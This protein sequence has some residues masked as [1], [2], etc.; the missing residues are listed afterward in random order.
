MQRHW[1]NR[2]RLLVRLK[3]HQRPPLQRVSL[4]LQSRSSGL[5][6]IFKTWPVPTTLHRDRPPTSRSH[7]FLQNNRL[8]ICMVALRLL[9]NHNRPA[10]RLKSDRLPTTPQILLAPTHLL[11]TRFPADRLQHRPEDRALYPWTQIQTLTFLTDPLWTYL[12]RKGNCPTKILMLLLPTRIRPSQRTSIIG[13]Q[14]RGIRSFMGWTHIPDMDSAAATSDDNPFAGPKT[15]ATGKV[16]VKMPTDEW[17]CRKMGKLKFTLME[18]YPSR[19][20]E[21]GGLLKDQFVRPARSQSKWYGSVPNQQ[22]GDTGSGKTV[23][24]WSTDASKVNSTYSH[25]ARAAGIASTPPASRPISQDNLR[26]WEKCAREASTICNQAASFNRC[27][28]KVQ[29]NM[30]SQLRLIKSDLGKSSS[31]MSGAADE[32]Q[33]LMTFNSSITQA[34][35]KTLEHLSDFVFVTVANTTLARRDSYLS[36]LKDGI[37][38]DTLAALRTAPLHISTLFPEEALKQAE[39]DIANFERCIKRRV[40]RSLKRAHGQ[41]FLVTTRKQAAHKLSRVKGSLSGSKRVPRPLREQDSSCSNRQH[42]SSVIYKQGRRHEVGPT[43]CP[44]VENLD[45]VYPETSD[46]QSPTHPRPVECGSRQAIPARPDH[47]DRVVSPSRG[48]SNYMQQV[49]PA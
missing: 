8:Q 30:Q 31:R 9:L 36:H 4:H 13:K 27:L 48:L 35:A 21:A 20:S 24:S 41:S 23:S 45:L 3:S 28:Y 40:G 49:E 29:E 32:L 22:K 7:P 16:S 11:F 10:S 42:Y 37:K 19:S 2:N 43:L 5:L 46:S 6:R 26:R 15:Q 34:M 39:Q 17:L 44:A 38:P 47:S 18:G 1:I 33:F 25:I 14:M 12:W